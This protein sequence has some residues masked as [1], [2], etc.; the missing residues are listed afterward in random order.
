VTDP[1]TALLALLL[2]GRRAGPP[3]FRPAVEALE[4]RSLPSAVLPTGHHH[5]AVAAPH[6][7][8]HHAHVAAHPHHHHQVHHRRHPAHTAAP[9][10]PST[11]DR[12]AH[13]AVQQVENWLWP[14]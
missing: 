3:A 14:F 9:A 2:P 12:I 8:R 4:G 10:S 1:L 11:G 5:G 13:E 6:P 7:V